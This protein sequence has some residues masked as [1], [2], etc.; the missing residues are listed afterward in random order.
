MLNPL[1]KKIL[2]TKNTLEIVKK[3]EKRVNFI[4]IIFLIF[5]I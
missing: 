2:K 1:N 5:K 4:V 3:L